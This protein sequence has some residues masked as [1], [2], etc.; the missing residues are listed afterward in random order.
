MAPGCPFGRDKG[1]DRVLWTKNR[2][3]HF[4][5]ASLNAGLEALVCKEVEGENDRWGSLGGMESHC[6]TIKREVVGE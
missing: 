4:K 2:D 1:D 3:P 6:K 5:V